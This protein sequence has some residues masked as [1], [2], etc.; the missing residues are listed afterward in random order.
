MRQ[1]SLDTT[2]GELTSWIL[3]YAETKRFNTYDIPC[4]ETMGVIQKHD[5]YLVMMMIILTQLICSRS[6]QYLTHQPGIF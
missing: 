1:G 4:N 5:E 2:V 3:P 6:T